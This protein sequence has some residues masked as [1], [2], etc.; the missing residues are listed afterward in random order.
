M[1][2]LSGKFQVQLEYKQVATVLAFGVNQM[3]WCDSWLFWQGFPFFLIYDI[4]AQFC[5]T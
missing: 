3:T 5:V 4:A 1:M 2:H